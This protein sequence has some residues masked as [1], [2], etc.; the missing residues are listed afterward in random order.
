MKLLVDTCYLNFMLSSYALVISFENEYHEQSSITVLAGPVILKSYA[1]LPRSWPAASCTTISACPVLFAFCLVAE[2]AR[3]NPIRWLRYS[4][5][6]SIFAN[7]PPRAPK[8][9]TYRPRK[10]LFPR[11][12]SLELSAQSGEFAKILKIKTKN[13]SLMKLL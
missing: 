9:S 2:P 6:L 10:Q 1:N 13:L 12:K 11:K 7:E 4:S 8:P 3:A 5:R